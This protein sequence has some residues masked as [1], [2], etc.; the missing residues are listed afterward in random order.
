VAALTYLAL[1]LRELRDVDRRMVL[2]EKA[3]TANAN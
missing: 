1:K 2:E 3:R